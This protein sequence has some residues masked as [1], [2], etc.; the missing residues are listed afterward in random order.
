MTGRAWFVVGLAGLGTWAM[1]A[2]LIV[3]LGRVA[4]PPLL[5]R[6]FRY[7]APSVM[8]AICVPAFIAPAGTVMM[9]APHILA[10]ALAGLVAWRFG[11]FLA[12]LAVGLAAF[13]L[14]SSLL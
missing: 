9:S 5:E 12:T 8:A 11:S 6:S 14:F 10:G 3:L 7:V 13:T 4:V 2:S 1:R